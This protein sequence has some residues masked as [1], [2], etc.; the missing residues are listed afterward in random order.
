MY[1]SWRPRRAIVAAT[2]SEE[3]EEE[4][5]PPPPPPPPRVKLVHGAV[6]RSGGT[7]GLLFLLFGRVGLVNRRRGAFGEC[8]DGQQGAGPLHVFPGPPPRDRS[9]VQRNP[10]CN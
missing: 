9:L 8:D 2:R 4:E 5:E 1:V 7:S 6:F 10:S 3:E